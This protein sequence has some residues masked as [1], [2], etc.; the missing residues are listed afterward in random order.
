MKHLAHPIIGDPKHG[1]SRHNR[2][3]AEEYQC[4]RLLLAA[5]QLRVTHPILN[6]G[7][8]LEAPIGGEF[9]SVLERFNWLPLT[10]NEER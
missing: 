9:K 2:F 10:P 7:I 4:A 3:F 8:V 1:K 6:K 5:K